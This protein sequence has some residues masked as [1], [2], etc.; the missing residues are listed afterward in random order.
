M[1]FCVGGGGER[2]AFG[3][4]FLN[5]FNQRA[6]EAVREFMAPANLASPTRASRFSGDPRVDWGKPMNG[7]GAFAG[8]QSK[9]TLASRYGMPNPWQQERNLRLAVD[10][11]F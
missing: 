6:T 3:A 5:L 4:T 8:V 9:P 1:P 7:T 2:I 11:T 10:F